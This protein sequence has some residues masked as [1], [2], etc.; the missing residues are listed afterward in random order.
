MAT[1]KTAT[2]KKKSSVKRISQ[3]KKLAKKAELIG[4]SPKYESFRLNKDINFMSFRVTKQTIYWSILII[5]ILIMQLWILNTQ[6]D[7][8]QIVESLTA[9]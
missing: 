9:V 6:L 8:L 2:T 4:P 7:V 1:K 3:L 5:F